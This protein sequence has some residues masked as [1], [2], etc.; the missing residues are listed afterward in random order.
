LARSTLLFVNVKSARHEGRA[1]ILATLR[2]GCEVVLLSG[3]PGSWGELVRREVFADF[4]DEAS[5]LATAH[6]L[7]HEFGFAGVV[8]WNEQAVQPAAKISA[9]LGLPGPSPLA[10]MLARDKYKMRLA[11]RQLPSLLPRY[12]RF[13]TEAELARGL[14]HVGFPAVIKPVSSSAGNGV[15]EVSSRAEATAAWHELRQLRTDLVA[16]DHRLLA[17]FVVEEYMAGDEVS[18]EG[19]IYRGEVLVLAVTDKLTIGPHHLE[20]QHI[21]PSALSPAAIASAV[22]CA[23]AV[24]TRL[25]LDNCAFHLEAKIDSGRARLVE[26]GARAGGGYIGS[27]LASLATGVD[28]YRETVRLALGERPLLAGSHGPDGLHA[29]IR[30]LV[31]EQAGTFT[32]LAGIEPVLRLANVE[33]V[34]LA[35]SPGERICLPPHSFAGRR[36]AAVVACHPTYQGVRDTLAQ[37]ARVCIPVVT[38]APEPA[39]PIGAALQGVG[40]R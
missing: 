15:Y 36:V 38:S 40:T 33:H 4:A 12:A 6:R 7:H 37:A 24:V 18:V 9:A 13:R 27:H 30:Y 5:M 22:E 35:R 32:G 26:V 31:A 8:G 19:W 11:L 14:S 28:F 29:G 3:R 23:A 34:F 20:L 1:A 16:P 25:G 21:L 10:A 2:L 17:D 39:H